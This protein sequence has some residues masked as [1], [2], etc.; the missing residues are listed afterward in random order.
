VATALDKTTILGNESTEDEGSDSHKL[1]QNV[2]RWAG[3]ILKWVTD[4]ITANGSFVLVRLLGNENWG[5]LQNFAVSILLSLSGSRSVVSLV[6]FTSLNI[7]LAVV[8]SATSIGGGEGNLDT[9]GDNTCEHAG[10]ELVSEDVSK[11][12]G[13]KNDNASWGNHLLEGS[14]G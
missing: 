8:P 1:D 5:S 12:E 4:G 11:D 2:D 13:G 3:G 10:D 7:L 14:S 9:G 6:E